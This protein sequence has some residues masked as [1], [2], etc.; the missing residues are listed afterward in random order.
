MY[1]KKITDTLSSSAFFG[2]GYVNDGMGKA[3]RFI[4][5]EMKQ[6]GLEVSEQKFTYAVN[7]FP[8]KMTLVINGKQLQPGI[9]FIVAPESRTVQGAGL[10]RQSDSVTW[11]NREHKIMITMVDKLTMSVSEGQ[12]NYTAFK[13]LKSADLLTAFSSD[14]EAKMERKFN[15]AN[16]AGTIM[17][18]TRPDSIIVF[19]A[20]FDHLGGMGA[21][22]YFPGANDNA[23]GVA[24][25]LSLAKYYKAH[26]SPYTMMF[27][28]FA[29]E[30]AGLL[31]SKYY[32]EHPLKPL[33]QIRFLINLDLVGNG[34][35]GITVVNASIFPTEFGLL[36]QINNKK[37]LFTTVNSRGKA[38]NSDHYWFSEKGVPSFFIYTLG[39]RKSYHDVQ[40]ISATVPWF[41][42][43]DLSELLVDFADNLIR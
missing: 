43:N 19:T 28:A 39:K 9:D 32:V 42:V 7:T 21:T 6:I 25:M 17:G 26:P 37:Q 35:E 12:A 1:I 15:C 34:E 22:T 20:H 10:L 18:T 38:A 8:G 36:Q 40:D 31:G 13:V 33:N 14:I 24:L 29:G 30:E 4:L 27:I 11:T 2:R 23:G 3:G 5:N 16:I 41:E